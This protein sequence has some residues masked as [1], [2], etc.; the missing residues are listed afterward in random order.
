M[1][2]QNG[3]S[4]NSNI[5]N[6]NDNPFKNKLELLFFLLIYSTKVVSLMRIIGS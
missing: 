6:I 2:S 3:L 1:K 4:I 5:N